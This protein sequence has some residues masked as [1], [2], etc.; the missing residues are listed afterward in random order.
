VAR[1]RVAGADRARSTRHLGVRRRLGRTRRG[2]AY[3]LIAALLLRGWRLNLAAVVIVLALSV[4]GLAALRAS[5]PDEL[6]A[7]IQLAGIDP[8][9]VYVVEVPGYAPSDRAYGDRLGTGQFMPTDPA[10]I[11]PIQYVNIFGYD[12]GYHRVPGGPGCG[13]TVFDSPLATAECTVEPG[14]TVYRRGVI[15]HGYQVTVGDSTVDVVGSHAVE[16]DLLRSAV[17]SVRAGTP[18]DLPNHLGA[19]PFFVA[20]VPGFRAQPIGI[21]PGVQYLRADHT[22]GDRSVQITVFAVRTDQGDACFMS[23]CRPEGTD[24]IYLRRDDV[25]GYVHHRGQAIVTAEGGVS[26]DRDLLRNVALT[27]RPATDAELIRALPAPPPRDRFDRLRAWLRS[28]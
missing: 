15:E 10:A 4:T 26:V 11:P 23:T 8:D 13:E 27:A 16:R 28:L 25:H 20:D 6:T 2:L 21:P 22:S 7:R 14:G 17:R 1:R 19:G 9:L 3:A 5:G 24:L 18:A 12:A